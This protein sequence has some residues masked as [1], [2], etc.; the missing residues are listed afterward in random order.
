MLRHLGIEFTHEEASQ[1]QFEAWGGSAPEV[2][3]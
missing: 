2:L 3:S 1:D